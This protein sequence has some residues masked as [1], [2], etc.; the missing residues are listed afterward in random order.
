MDRSTVQK[1][2][3]GWLFLVIAGVLNGVLR[4]S[5]LSP[6][7]G[8]QTSYVV[9]TLILMIAVLICSWVLANRFLRHSA[10]RDLLI[11]CLLWVS[12]SASLELFLGHYVLGTPW[13][14]LVQEYNLLSGRIRIVVLL[15]ELIGP[16]F[17][18][19]NGR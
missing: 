14:T 7:M 10:T 11:I 15:T 17:M 2:V 1:A 6:Q 19:S 5:L 9:S 8:E 18:A 12:L 3:G 4:T 16:W 13:V